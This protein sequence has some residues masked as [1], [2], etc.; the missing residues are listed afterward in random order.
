M[1]KTISIDE[2]VRTNIRE[3]EP[4]HSARENF[5]KGTLLDANENSLGSPIKGAEGLHRYPS[6]FHPQLRSRI[7]ER[8]GLRTENVFTGV[9]SDEAIDLLVRIFCE[10]GK[11]RILITP[12]TYGMYKV[13]ANIHDIYVDQVPLTDNFDIDTEGVLNAI[14]EDTKLLFFCSPNNPTGND[15]SVGAIREIAGRFSGIVVVDEAYVDFSERESLAPEIVDYPNMV[16]LQTF[17]KAFGLAGIR[18]GVAFAAEEI[19]HYMLKIKAPYN[20]NSLT[21]YYALEAMNNLD[22]IRFNIEKI[23]E[24]RERL[25]QALS[26]LSFVEEVYPTDANFILFKLNGDAH[27]VYEKMA[28]RGIIVRYRGDQPNCEHCLRVT[29]GTPDENDRFLSALKEVTP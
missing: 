5:E 4:Y 1:Q 26:M 2:L 13:T 23:V 7:A 27:G 10:P 3:L 11:D 24:E 25:S 18:L 21:A 12:P 28:E 16:V 20:V 19:V 14:G 9:G 17:S 8:R 15:L 29:V 22:T 6:P